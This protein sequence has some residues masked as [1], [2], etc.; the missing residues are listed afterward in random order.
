MRLQV[1]VNRIR[2]APAWAAPPRCSTVRL[3][4]LVRLAV[5][6]GFDGSAGSTMHGRSTARFSI[7]VSSRTLVVLVRHSLL[8]SLRASAVPE[9]SSP[10]GNLTV[11]AA[12]RAFPVDDVAVGVDE[13]LDLAGAG[14]PV[15]TS[16]TR[17][18]A[19]IAAAGSGKRRA[20]D[21]PREELGKQSRRARHVCNRARLVQKVGEIGDP[22][23]AHRQLPAIV[24]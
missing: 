6:V 12:A 22:G 23:V 5:L 21:D 11:I 3:A 1:R 15:R 8:H 4:A 9:R 19:S 16:P 18:T 10:A 24:C 14:L 2:R 13:I 17:Q 20:H 7:R